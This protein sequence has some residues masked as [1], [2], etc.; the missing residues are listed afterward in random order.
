MLRHLPV[1]DVVNSLQICKAWA[2]QDGQQLLFRFLLDR[3]FGSPFLNDARL[4]R[5]HS[6]EHELA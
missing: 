5:G 4:L 3:D 6:G 1:A 2:L